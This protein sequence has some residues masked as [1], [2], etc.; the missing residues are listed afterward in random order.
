[1]HRLTAIFRQHELASFRLT[2]RGDL[3]KTFSC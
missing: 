1:M 2:L 3:Y